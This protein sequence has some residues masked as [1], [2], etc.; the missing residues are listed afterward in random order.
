MNQTPL[1]DRSLHDLPP[2]GMSVRILRVNMVLHEMIVQYKLLVHAI[3]FKTL[4]LNISKQH[5]EC[6]VLL[7][8]ETRHAF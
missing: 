6:V 7:S 4:N 3:M 2:L 8:S 5:L 1:S